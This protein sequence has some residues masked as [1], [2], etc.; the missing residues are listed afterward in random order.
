MSKQVKVLFAA[1]GTGGHLFP[2]T[3]LA[4]QLQRQYPSAKILFAGAA[5]SR[6]AYFDKGSFLFK[7]I[8]SMTPFGGGLRRAVASVMTLLR[9]VRESFALLASEKPDLVIGFGSFHTFPILL[10][11]NLKKIPYILFESNAISGKV[12]RLFSK[13]A[14]FTGI[15]FSEA[16]NSLKGKTVEVE[17]PMRGKNSTLKEEARSHFRLRPDLPTVLVFGGS[18]GARR[19][20]RT[21]IEMLPLLK[22]TPLQLIHLTGCEQ[23]ASEVVSL[24]K[25]LGVHCFAS[26]FESQMHL[27]WSAADLV[28]CRAGAMTLAELVHYEVPG[29][30][31]PYP[32]AAEQHQRKNAEVFQARVGGAIPLMEHLLTPALLAETLQ[33]LLSAQSP[34]RV[35]MQEAVKQFKRQQKRMDLSQLIVHLLVDTEANA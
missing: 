23:T 3:A 20:N 11:V 25:E 30:L 16:K 4:E 32:A 10:A 28:I 1:G 6:N 5:L 19:I 21:L 26:K 14:L 15:Y 18:Q 27:A 8:T 33:P 17:I 31:I 13:R 24:C 35:Q 2:A 9:G 34:Q 29:I 12:V 7:D 22:N